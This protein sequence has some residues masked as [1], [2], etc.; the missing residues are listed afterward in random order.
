ML[1]VG[2]CGRTQL[3]KVNFYAPHKKLFMSSTAEKLYIFF[4][5]FSKCLI[6]KQSIIFIRNNIVCL[7][8]W[9]QWFFYLKSLESTIKI[10]ELQF[11]SSVS[12]PSLLNSNSVT[13]CPSVLIN[14]SVTILFFLLCL[15]DHS[16]HYYFLQ[17]VSWWCIGLPCY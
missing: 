9:V 12:S 4:D 6:W 15:L 10:E 17:I 14:P 7:I 13:V 3:Y 5:I 8:H 11:P 1:G 16:N 2:G